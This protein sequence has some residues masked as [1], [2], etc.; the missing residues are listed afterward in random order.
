MFLHQL[1][2]EEKKAF[3]TLAKEFIMVDGELSPEEEELLTQMMGEL[4]ITDGF[5]ENEYTR[6]QLFGMFKNRRARV[7]TIIEMQGL[8]YA[9]MEYHTEEIAFI[10][11]M[12]KAFDIS[13]DELEGIDDWVVRQVALL[14]EANDFWAEEPA[15]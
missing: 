13:D 11:E 12:A 15:R 2:Q 1:N 5:K 4:G 9:N 7:A 6:Q 14:H 3:I 8:G 10:E